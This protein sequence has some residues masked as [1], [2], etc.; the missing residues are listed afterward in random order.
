MVTRAEDL[1]R[2]DSFETSRHSTATCIS[3]EHYLPQVASVSSRPKPNAA[4]RRRDRYF[5][6]HH[7]SLDEVV[8]TQKGSSRAR[9]RNYRDRR[10][11]RYELLHRLQLKRAR[12]RQMR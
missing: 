4:A 10:G 2:G 9:T 5:C 3:R 8:G 6:E 7:S 11:A 12:A 1:F